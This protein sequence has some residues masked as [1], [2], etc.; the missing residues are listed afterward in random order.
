[1]IRDEELLRHLYPVYRGLVVHGRHPYSYHDQATSDSIAITFGVSRQTVWRRM[2]D[3]QERGLIRKIW[4]PRPSGRG[5]LSIY[6]LTERA[7]REVV[8]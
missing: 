1:M 7:A 8:R 5:P 2:K 3:L 6:T 4:I